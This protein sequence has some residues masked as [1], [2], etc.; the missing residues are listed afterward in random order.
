RPQYRRQSPQWRRELGLDGELRDGSGPCVRCAAR[1]SGVPGPHDSTRRNAG[2]KLPR[3]R[4]GIYLPGL[5]WISLDRCVRRALYRLRGLNRRESDGSLP[6]AWGRYG[7]DEH[8]GSSGG[9]VAAALSGPTGQVSPPS[10][11]SSNPE[12]ALSSSSNG[13]APGE[14]SASAGQETAQSANSGG[15]SE[16][17][18]TSSETQRQVSPPPSAE[19]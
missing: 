15:A 4:R 7:H 1:V 13:S 5:R 12:P 19:K 3:R 16:N 18:T 17:R 8:L 10:T 14:A 11:A 9:G 6:P 2:R